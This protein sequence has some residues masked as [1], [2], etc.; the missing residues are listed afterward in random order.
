[1]YT[2]YGK[3][4]TCSMAVHVVLNEL[5]QKLNY[6]AAFDAQGKASDELKKLNPVGQIP[7]LVD[8]DI[9]MTEGAAIMAYLMDKHASPMLP[10]AGAGRAAALQWLAFANATM[11]PAYSRVF[12]LKANLGAEAATSELMTV[13][14]K[15]INE[16]WAIV[17]AR[18][19]AN[20]Y[21]CGAQISAADILLTVIANWTGNVPQP[22][23]LGANVKRLLKEVST[24]PAYQQALKSEGV[25]YK[26]AA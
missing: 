15:K 11:H 1:M 17:D 9:V 4:G 25:E 19:A 16:L 13:A 3:N 22:V 8:G 26:A 14:V 20:P 6:I 10:K 12:F 7:V 24:R 5:S 18:L 2:L 23:T 21:I